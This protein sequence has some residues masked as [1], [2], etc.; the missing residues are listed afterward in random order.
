MSPTECAN[1]A[2]AQRLYTAIGS[3]DFETI[4][5]IL[6][7]DVVVRE[8]SGLP[9]GGCYSGHDGFFDLMRRLGECWE[10]L[11]P[12]DM[13]YAAGDD[14]VVMLCTLK[15]ISRATGRHLCQPLTE[16]WTF[17]DG[18]AIEGTVSYHDTHAVRQIC[19]LS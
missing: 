9:Y 17:R 5:S 4:N 12:F 11:S 15:G 2:L 6:S 3:G 16:A 14:T 18:R 10:D 8:A 7:P 19:G 13:K 1:I